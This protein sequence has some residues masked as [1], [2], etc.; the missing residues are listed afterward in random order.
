MRA[1][2]ITAVDPRRLP[3]PLRPLPQRRGPAGRP[4][5]RAV[6]RHLGRPRGV[7]RLR[8]R[9]PRRGQRDHGHGRLRPA[10]GRGLPGVVGAHA[11]ALRPADR[12][13]PESSTATSTSAAWPGST[14]STPA[15]TAPRST[16]RRPS[17][18][19]GPACE[20][21]F[22]PD[23]DLLGTEQEA[24]LAESL[25]GD[26]RVWD[27]VGNQVVL[28][29]W[30]FGP[31]EDAIFNLDQ[32]DGY[33]EARARVTEALAGAA[34]RRRRA[35]RR[36]P[37]DVGGRPEGGLRRRGVGPGRHRAGRPRRRLRGRASIAII[38]DAIL[39]QQPPHPL[40]RGRRTGAGCATSSPR[41]TGRPR[42]ASS[43]TPSTAAARWPADA[44]LRHPNRVEPVTE[45]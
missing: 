45:A 15:S 42:S 21:S 18:R 22:D 6:G 31:G 28:H 36:R 43:P 26:D 30:R 2:Q 23:D 16:A 9:P 34:G 8:R 25:T 27:V 1:G 12:P 20:T 29:Q 19:S 33:P 32:W 38:E 24:W 7:E 17:A 37:L 3:P 5:G 39:T 13:R 14:S 10:P 40:Q 35:H 44:H 11:G 4:R 41:R